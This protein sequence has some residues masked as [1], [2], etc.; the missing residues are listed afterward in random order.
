[1]SV[2]LCQR[3]G[4]IDAVTECLPSWL[5]WMKA[6]WPIRSPPTSM[7]SGMRSMTHTRRECM[8]WPPATKSI[9]VPKISD[10]KPNAWML[11][12]WL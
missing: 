1:M 6:Y 12:K 3:K 4:V 9:S 5:V 2:L 11:W 10:R 8:K 7:K